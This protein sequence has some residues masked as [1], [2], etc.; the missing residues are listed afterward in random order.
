ME[1]FKTE[2]IKE[3]IWD[4]VILE[5]MEDLYNYSQF[6]ANPMRNDAGGS[7]EC[8]QICKALR[9]LLERLRKEVRYEKDRGRRL[10]GNAFE[11]ETLT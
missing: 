9:P 1:D 11:V 5:K 2:T 7:M 3:P 4:E 10:N 8:A 6:Y